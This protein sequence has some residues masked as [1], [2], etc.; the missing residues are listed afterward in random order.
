MKGIIYKY[1]NKINGKVYIGQTINPKIRKSQHKN[2]KADD[3]FHRAIRK[4]GWEAFDY[5][6][7]Y[8]FDL[9]T[10]LLR[11]TLN[12]MEIRLIDELKPEYN[13]TLG[14]G[15]T[16][17]YQA[18]INVIKK[19]TEVNLKNTRRVGCKATEETKKL[20]SKKL[21]GKPLQHNRAILQF[22]LDGKFIKRF[23]S[24][25]KAA[26]ELNICRTNIIKVCRGKRRSTSYYIFKYEEDFIHSDNTNMCVL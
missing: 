5:E 16:S 18:P 19:S 15:G 7:L 3:Y 1:T 22:S 9:P 4:Y 21:K 14:G 10:N 17:G 6:V 13:I 23:K 25:T 24:A 20:L 26:E 11:S 2:S 8:E 12:M